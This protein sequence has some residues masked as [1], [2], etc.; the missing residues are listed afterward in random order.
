M[1]I[2]KAFPDEPQYSD[3]LKFYCPACKEYHMVSVGPK[4]FWREKWTFNGNYE[5]PTI[6]AS[7]LV[8]RPP[9][10]HCHSFVT[11]GKIQYLS[12]CSHE[13]RGQTVELPDIEN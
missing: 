3:M 5:K 6:R 2:I 7:V 11:D 12:D 13:M 9:I 8:E 1:K 10:L 4:S